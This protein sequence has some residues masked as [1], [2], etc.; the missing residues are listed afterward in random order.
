MANYL[1]NF[2]IFLIFKRN[3]G[4]LTKSGFFVNLE[5]GIGLGGVLG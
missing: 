2:T 1:I 3:L 5:G 4:K